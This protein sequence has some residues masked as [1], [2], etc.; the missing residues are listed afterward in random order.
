MIPTEPTSINHRRILHPVLTGG[1]IVDLLLVDAAGNVQDHRVLPVDATLADTPEILAR[2]P[3]VLSVRIDPEANPSAACTSCHASAHA[4]W[5]V[6]KHAHA[7]D[8]LKPADR[9]DSC[10]GCHTTPTTEKTVA[11]GVG[12]QACH[13]GSAAHVRASGKERPTA[14]DCRGCHDAKHNPAFDR[15]KAWKVIQH[16]SGEVGQGP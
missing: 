6:S 5:T 13:T 9:T 10:I 1:L 8:S 2:F 16:G 7:L 3:D 11:A 12:C 14:V 15:E 4:A